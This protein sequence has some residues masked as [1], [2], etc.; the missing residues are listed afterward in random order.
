MIETSNTM[1]ILGP[2]LPFKLRDSVM[3]PT[4]SGKGVILL[5]GYNDSHRRSSNILLELTGQSLDTLRYKIILVTFFN[6]VV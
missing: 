5:G 4:P 1:T 3:I 6:Y 2:K